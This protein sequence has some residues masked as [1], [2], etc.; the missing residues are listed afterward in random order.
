MHCAIQEFFLLSCSIQVFL[1]RFLIGI[2]IALSRSCVTIAIN[3]CPMWK[4]H[5]SKNADTAS[6]SPKATLPDRPTT[7]SHLPSFDE[8]RQLILF[9]SSLMP[10]IEFSVRIRSFFAYTF[11]FAILEICMLKILASW[12]Q[13][14]RKP[15]SPKKRN[16][17]PKTPGSRPK[18]ARHGRHFQR[19][20]FQNL[21]GT[22]SWEHDEGAFK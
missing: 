19:P 8:N 11:L 1:L 2:C 9:R 6:T 4:V 12:L 14:K 16:T 5:L 20:I 10:H 21:P 22:Q 7:P 18:T 13:W 17:Y 15:P 3:L